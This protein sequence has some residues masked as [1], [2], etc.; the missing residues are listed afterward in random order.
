[1]TEWQLDGW[2]G[3]SREGR[4]VHFAGGGAQAARPDNVVLLARAG[5]SDGH[6]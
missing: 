2:V 3:F 6:V 5:G 4:G 1:M